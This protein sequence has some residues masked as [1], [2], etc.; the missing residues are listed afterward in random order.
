MKT[1]RD[2]LTESKKVYSFKVKLAG[3]IPENFVEDLKKRLDTYEIV[4][5]E[6]MSTPVEETAVDFSQHG[7]KEITVFDLVVEYPITAPEIAAY[8]KEMN[9][10]EECFRVRGSMEPSEYDQRMIENE[11]GSLL[12]D[13]FYKD[14]SKIKH[15]DY[16]GDDFNKDFLKQLAKEAKERKKELKQDKG[17]PD[18]LG[19]APK[20]KQDKAGAKSAMGS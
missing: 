8:L 13:P 15:K 6:K 10:S 7:D 2:Y 5:L 19:S 14:D 17:D 4:T 1:F 9:I 3:E 12:D 20:F 11:A 18:V 16:F